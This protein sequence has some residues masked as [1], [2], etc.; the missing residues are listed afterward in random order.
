MGGYL[1]GGER[2]KVVKVTGARAGER[3]QY[4]YCLR[5]RRFK[6]RPVAGIIYI[7][8][9]YKD[10]LVLAPAFGEDLAFG[11][12]VEPFL[13]RFVYAHLQKRL[14]RQSP[15]PY[16]RAGHIRADV[17]DIRIH[18]VDEFSLRDIDRDGAGNAV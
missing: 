15:V 9:E 18:R 11:L 5:I 16:L 8:S 4:L 10:I 6:V 3:S 17:F 12:R 1:K 7:I 2:K 13:D 14:A